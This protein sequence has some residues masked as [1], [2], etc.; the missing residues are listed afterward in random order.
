MSLLERKSSVEHLGSQLPGHDY[1]ALES[2]DPQR[3]E[4]GDSCAIQ[5][6]E[7]ANESTHV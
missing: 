3:A 2:A 4:T 7:A 6:G 1:R 5:A